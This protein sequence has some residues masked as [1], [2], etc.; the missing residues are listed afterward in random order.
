MP[1]I[2][3]LHF[4]SQL[5]VM[6]AMRRLQELSCTING[7][8]VT[9][10]IFPPRTRVRNGNELSSLDVNEKLL[11]SPPLD[12]NPPLVVPSKQRQQQP[13]AP[14]IVP[15]FK[16]R[17]GG[18]ETI[19]ELKQRHE[20]V[21]ATETKPNSEMT[22]AAAKT[23]TTITTATKATN[24]IQPDTFVHGPLP[25]HTRYGNR[26]VVLWDTE[27]VG[28]RS[29][30][31][32]FW[33]DSE[34]LRKLR[35]NLT[36]IGT[37]LAKMAGRL[38]AAPQLQ[39]LCYAVA[40]AGG[41]YDKMREVFKMS[42]WVTLRDASTKKGG[43]DVV[44]FQTFVD[45]IADIVLFGEM[46]QVVVLI[47]GDGDFARIPQTCRKFNIPFVLVYDEETVNKSLIAETKG[48]AIPFG[49]AISS[50]DSFQFAGSDKSN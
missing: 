14:T 5:S 11:S 4:K 33:V 17:E 36:T 47:S 44:I 13:D 12:S 25:K 41:L 10:R 32:I 34:Q 16:T 21:V 8:R 3:Y 29:G 39:L 43:V 9:A 46:P 20:N 45:I 31:T 26:I 42:D 38:P 37:V 18:A 7:V 2:A 27:N 50:L 28:P 40:N 49:C 24:N 1:T 15:E 19:T 6:A 22:K 48:C 35:D 30:S 23:T